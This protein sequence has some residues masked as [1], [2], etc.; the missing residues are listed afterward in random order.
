V[1]HALAS[2]EQDALLKQMEQG[3]LTDP[4]WGGHAE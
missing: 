4:A 3:K 1:F 2:T